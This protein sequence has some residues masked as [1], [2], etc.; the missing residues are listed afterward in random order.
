MSDAEVHARRLIGTCIRRHI[1]Y[2]I[3]QYAWCAI[4]SEE[5]SSMHTTQTRLPCL[6]WHQFPSLIINGIC[7]HSVSFCKDPKDSLLK[8]F[9]LCGVSLYSAHSEK[10]TWQQRNPRRSPVQHWNCCIYCIYIGHTNVLAKENLVKKSTSSYGCIPA[11]LHHENK[12]TVGES[13]MGP[14]IGAP[15]A[16]F[17]G[18]FHL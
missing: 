11:I 12:K 10:S 3:P 4:V 14:H 2:S 9:A 13:S 7:S 16:T 5:L 1:I 17:F 15:D 8:S 18:H 6:W